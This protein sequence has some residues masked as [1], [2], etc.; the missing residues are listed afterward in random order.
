MRIALTGA[1]GFIGSAIVRRLLAKGHTLRILT[2]R[3]SVPQFN[4]Y[5]SSVE[6]VHGDLSGKN[7]FERFVEG[8]EVVVNAAGEYANYSKMVTVNLHG[9]KV[10]YDCAIRSGVRHWIQLSSVGAY[11]PML[12]GVVTEDF[13]DSPSGEYE[14]T[15]SAFDQWLRKRCGTGGM[16]CTVLRPSIVFGEGMPNQSLYA[17]VRSIK[18]GQFFFIGPS[19]ANMNYVH[20]EDVAEAVNACLKSSVS[21]NK[22]YILSDCL[23]LEQ[24]VFAISQGLNVAPPA[25]RIPKRLAVA[26][27]FA[28]KW[29]KRWPLTIQRVHALSNRTQYATELIANDLGWRVRHSLPFYIERFARS[30]ADVSKD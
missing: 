28:L 13:V 8:V 1:S 6:I 3:S 5:S 16:S 20:V 24:F 14:L 25:L 29:H 11:G 22:T 10:L 4:D 27:A 21:Y 7:D 19:G 26:S 9:P 12:D 17:L 18:R 15:K 23:S 30:V 2:R